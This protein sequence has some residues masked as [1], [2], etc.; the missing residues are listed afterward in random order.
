MMSA[1]DIALGGDSKRKTQSA[2]R[3]RLRPGPLHAS[4]FRLLSFVLCLLLSAHLSGCARPKDDPPIWENVKLKD[5]APSEGGARPSQKVKTINLDL[6]V[7]E[8]PAEN[9]DKLDKIR[10]KL[11]VRPL[12]LTDYGAFYANSFWVRFGQP[13]MWNEVYEM[14]QAAAGQRVNRV[15]LMLPEGWPETF[16]ITG[17]ERPQ[18]ISYTGLDGSKEVAN[19]SPGILGLRIKATTVP[20]LPGQCTVTAYPVFTPPIQSPVSQLEAQAKRREFPFTVA[21]VGRAIPA[22]EI[23]LQAPNPYVEDRTTLGGLFF[24][25]PQGGLFV[26]DADQTLPER[27]PTVRV[28]LLICTRIDF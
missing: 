15:S 2:R 28:F 18:S 26:D 24:S 21:G 5:L 12:R 13:R 9:V 4:G 6:H 3:P 8:V 7:F 14:V 20:S 22:G 16:T 27:K 25:N 11:Y 23:V 17:S 10:K 19:V 1:P